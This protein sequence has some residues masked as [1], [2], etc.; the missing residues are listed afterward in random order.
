MIFLRGADVCDN[1]PALF[2]VKR[3]RKVN[4]DG[5]TVLEYTK[6]ALSALEKGKLL[7][8]A[9]KAQMMEMFHLSDR[10]QRC[11]HVAYTH[12][13]RHLVYGMWCHNC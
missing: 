8:T 2:L 13:Q 12:F 9:W 1:R 7:G 11:K 6:R 10:G 4:A 5:L 3:P